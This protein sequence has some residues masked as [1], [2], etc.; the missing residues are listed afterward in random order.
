M[1]VQQALRNAHTQ[2]REVSDAPHLDADR[3]LLHV[4][5]H[6]EASRLFAHGEE[7]LTT[8]EATQLAA[9]VR[10]RQAGEP[11]A[12]LMGEW[13]FY[14]RPFYV[15]PAVLIPR[16]STE[17]LVEA[18]LAYLHLPSTLRNIEERREPFLIADVGTG[19]GCIAVTLVLEARNKNIE[20]SIIATDISADA[21]TVAQ[22]NA[23]RY[24]VASA[25]EF[26]QGNLLEP[27]R[28]QVVDLIV[29]N[30]PYVPSAELDRAGNRP[31]TLGLSFEPRQAL[32]GGA[33]GW[34]YV[35]ELQRA[36]LPVI[37]ESQGGRLVST[38]R[39]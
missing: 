38:V 18:A 28:D 4:L 35:Q 15:S 16:P 22:R 26:V 17:T 25:I 2:L 20:L 37:L 27:L 8:A 30:P 21:L 12:Y 34:Q 13:E 31:D 1:T 32:D 19:S 29:S 10:R 24:G 14:G 9:L 3:L 5:G 6:G 11:L 39:A 36:V 33:D 23:K 7:Q